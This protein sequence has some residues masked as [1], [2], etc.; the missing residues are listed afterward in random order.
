VAHAP[1]IASQA[2]GAA[3]MAGSIETRRVIVIGG[4]RESRH[5]GMDRTPLALLARAR[6]GQASALGEICD[7]YRN[8][9]RVVVRSS[10]R[11]KLRDQVELSDVVQEVLVEM[12][13]QF[14]S[15]TGEDETT[16]PDFT[17]D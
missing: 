11:P 5:S 10:L 16:W 15:F 14:P 4:L 8:Y 7:H 6:S 2:F 13:R 17:I 12:V 1:I 9:L 3:G